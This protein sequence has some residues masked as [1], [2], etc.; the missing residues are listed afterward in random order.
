MS[1]TIGKALLDNAIDKCR[2]H[3]VSDGDGDISASASAFV[4]ACTAVEKSAGLCLCAVSDLL[5]SIYPQYKGLKPDA[6]NEDIY[7]VLEVLGWTVE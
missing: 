2:A 4:D 7:K 5:A 1:K 3:Y 6:S